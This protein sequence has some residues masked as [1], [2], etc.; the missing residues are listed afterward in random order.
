MK[1]ILLSW[2]SGKD[3]AWSL[4]V[5]RQRGEYE[6]AGLLTTFNEDAGRVAMHGVRRELV[7]RQ[8]S[9]AELPLWAVALPWPC[10]NE[11]YESLM[12][13]ACATAVSEGIEA[14]AFGDLFLED[15]RAYREKQ[16]A[17]SGLEPIFPL[18]GRPTRALAEEMIA[19]GLCAKLTCIDTTKLSQSFAGREFDQALLADLPDEADPCGE[20]GEFHSFVYAGPMLNGTVAVSVG[21]TVVRDQFAFADLIAE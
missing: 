4:H 19:G 5:L 8:A 17:G 13:Q 15:V 14:V 2:S 18:W 9:A 20:R 12:A 11:Q 10:S 21:V 7:E 1:R 16:M 3:S 6:V